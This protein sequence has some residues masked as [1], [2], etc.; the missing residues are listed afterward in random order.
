MDKYIHI[1]KLKVLTNISYCFNVYAFVMNKLMYYSQVLVHSTV[2]NSRISLRYIPTF[3]L[4]M[5]FRRS[6]HLSD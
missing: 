3:A 6:R 5:Q 2:V 1:E 4:I